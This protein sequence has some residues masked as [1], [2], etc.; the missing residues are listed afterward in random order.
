MGRVSQK[1]ELQTM[2]SIEVHNQMEI[3]LLKKTDI[4]FMGLLKNEGLRLN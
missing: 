1:N 2:Y 3:G 4:D